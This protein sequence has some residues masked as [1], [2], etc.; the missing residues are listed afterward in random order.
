MSTKDYLETRLWV[1]ENQGLPAE[2]RAYF[3][4]LET[5]LRANDIWPT[6]TTTSSTTTSSTSSTSSTTSTS[7][8]TTSSSTSST[9]S[10]TSTA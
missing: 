7:T 4:A 9:A 5:R 6:T 10:T 2:L 3:K 8:S 1:Q